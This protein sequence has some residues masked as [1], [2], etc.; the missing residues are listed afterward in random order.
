V[1]GLEVT[2]ITT[3]RGKVVDMRSVLCSWITSLYWPDVM[4]PVVLVRLR[5]AV[6]GV[7]H[8]VKVL[9]EEVFRSRESMSVSI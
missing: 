3:L 7:P 1:A 5:S 6:G 9:P 2:S 4:F 8:S